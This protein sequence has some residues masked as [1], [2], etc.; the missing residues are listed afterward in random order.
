M[1]CITTPERDSPAPTIAAI[2][3][4]GIRMLRR[5]VATELLGISASCPEREPHRA[6]NPSQTTDATS[7]A[8]METAPNPMDST[9]EATR[10]AV[11]NKR[12]IA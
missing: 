6:H 12:I 11:N 10:A 3:T 1:A 9:R 2:S 8:G 5:I 7:P 4:R